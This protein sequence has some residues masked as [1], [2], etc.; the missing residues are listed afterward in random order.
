MEE[1]CGGGKRL[2]V[3]K[4]SVTL[5]SGKTKERFVVHPGKAVAMLPV[6][7]EYCYLERQ[8]RFA[9]G[10]WLYEVPAGTMDEGETPEETAHRELIEETGMKAATFIP[11]GIIHP[12]PGYTDEVIA[13]YEARDLSPSN[14]Y[15]MDDDEMIEVVKVRIDEV[16]AMILSGEISDAKTICI[17]YRC[18]GCRR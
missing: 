17:M 15:Q 10:Q 3:E 8:Y 13:L 2:S 12:A 16:E 1:V 7:G 9:V 4:A 5:P 6:E 18:F 14:E 11:R